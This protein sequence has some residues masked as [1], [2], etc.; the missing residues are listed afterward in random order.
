MMKISAIISIIKKNKSI[1]TVYDNGKQWISAGDTA[2]NISALP[3][4]NGEQLLVML[5]IPEKKK[6]DYMV[7][8]N[9]PTLES[10]IDKSKHTE[11]QINRGMIDI[12]VLGTVYEPVIV[13]NRVYFI[14]RAYYKPFDGTEWDLAA[15]KD[16]QTGEILFA[17][18]TGFFPMAYIKPTNVRKDYVS[19]DLGLITET[20]KR[21]KELNDY[22]EEYDDDEE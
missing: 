19:L 11:H 10:I 18:K 12:A 9:S 3:E 14:D 7:I 16:K 6:E 20:L 21:E 5:G 4:L 2:Y 15:W 8:E 17:A 22:P 1:H 13:D